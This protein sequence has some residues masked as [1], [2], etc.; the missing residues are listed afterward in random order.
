MSRLFMLFILGLSVLLAVTS[1]FSCSNSP[2]SPVPSN[3]DAIIYTY[4]ITN[5]YPH[6]RDAFTQGLVF[7]DGVLYE[8]TGQYGHSSLRRVELET[9]DILQIRE[10]SEQ[11]FGE[12]ITIYGDEIIQLTW[13]SNV[14]FVYDKNNFELLGEF[15]YSTEGWGITHD[16]TRLIMSDGTATLH[17]LDPQ[18]FEEIGQLEVFDNDSPIARLNELEYIQGEIY[19]NVWQTDWVARIAPQTGRV[20]GWIDLSGLLTAE[21]RSEPVDVLNGIAYDAEDD[22]LFVTGKWWP[23]LFEIELIA[24]S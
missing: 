2:E 12:G 8:G 21:D 15:N 20:V 17:F 14:G 6:D 18:T 22:R 24:P 3:S 16:G 19:A 10:L 5:P 23:K 13:Q 4:N 7:E 1:G 9:G 11:F